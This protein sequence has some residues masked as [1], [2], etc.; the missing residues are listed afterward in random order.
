MFES[1]SKKYGANA[2]GVLLTG[3]FE[4][5]SQKYYA[6]SD[7]VLQSGWLNLSTGTY[8]LDA[9]GAMQ[10]GWVEADSK[11]Y[12]LNESGNPSPAGWL[13]ADGTRY[14]LDSTGAAKTGWL[15]LDDN[16]YYLKTDGAIA[17]G[18]YA[19]DGINHYFTSKGVE[20]IMANPWNFIPSG[21]TV[22]I[23]YVENDNYVD[24]SCYDALQKML[25]DC[26]AAGLNPVV[27]SGYRRHT[28][29][30]TLFNNKVN[31]YLN[32]GY[33]N[34]TA[35]EL[36]ATEIATPGTSEHE[37]GLAVDIIDNSYWVLDEYQEKTPA[38]QWLM[39]HC[40]EYGFILRY[41]NDK[42]AS[43]GIIYEPWHYRY[44]GVELALEIRD[45][46]LCLEEYFESLS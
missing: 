39:Q 34:K 31:Y 45:S 36:A 27:C 13:E 46:G 11:R 23:V 38:Q 21:Y 8:Y 4:L 7:G 18:K 19:V 37:L 1:D 42:S 28:T 43:T 44:V 5:N 2:D 3:W 17:K 15:E 24:R 41:P 9:N 6:G 25:R 16:T 12:H 26:R 30:I 14:Y 32:L 20:V 22:D 40:W 33:D 10:T 35:R 29:Q